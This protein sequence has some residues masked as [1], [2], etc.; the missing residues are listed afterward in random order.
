MIK[1]FVVDILPVQSDVS[2]RNPCLW[3]FGVCSRSRLFV[4]LFLHFHLSLCIFLSLAF[5]LHSLSLPFSLSRISY[6]FRSLLKDKSGFF[7]FHVADKQKPLF[8]RVHTGI[9]SCCKVIRGAKCA[10]LYNPLCVVCY[11]RR[12]QQPSRLDSSFQRVKLLSFVILCWPVCLGQWIT[13]C[14]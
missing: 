8:E 2:A 6:T 10:G 5:S 1:S 11:I 9:M 14:K 12:L 3:S 13:R 7:F 4:S